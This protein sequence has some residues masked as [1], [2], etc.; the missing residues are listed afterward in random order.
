[1]LARIR[2]ALL[3]ILETEIWPVLYRGNKARRL[4]SLLVVNGRISDR[5]FPSY[6]RWRFF[7]EDTLR[8]PDVILAQSDRDAE[9]YLKLGA[10]PHAVQSM[11]NLKYDAEPSLAEPPRVITELIAKLNPSAIWI[12]ASTMPGADR[13]DVDEDDAVLSAFEELAQTHPG[14]LLILVPRRPERFDEAEQKLR[15]AG[16]PYVRRSQ[17]SIP[18]WLEAS[19]VVLLDSIGELASLFAI[20][21]VVLMGGTLARRGGYNLL[22]PAACRKAIVTG[23]HLENFAAIAAEFREQRA[24]LEIRGAGELTGAVAKLLDDREL[25]QGLG[26]R[27][28]ALAASK[29]GATKRPFPKSSAGRI[30]QSRTGTS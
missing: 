30:W 11:G 13:D 9:R 17:E 4:R 5:A 6:R 27:A 7:F 25:R 26:A 24:F 21:D 28:A 10:P 19:T 8:F 14:L 20:A 22:E 12:A 2:P 16:L 23:P 3:V 18:P 1:M 29:R 15:T